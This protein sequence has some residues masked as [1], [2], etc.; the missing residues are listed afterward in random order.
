MNA[1]R[2]L[3]GPVQLHYRRRLVFTC[4]PFSSGKGFTEGKVEEGRAL[5]RTPWFG[6]LTGNKNDLWKCAPAV[7]PEL[8]GSR[9]RL[10]LL[11]AI[12]LQSST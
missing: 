11:K 8:T 1:A 6:I 7:S 12:S 10:E 9:A 4:L 2:M 5:G 3:G